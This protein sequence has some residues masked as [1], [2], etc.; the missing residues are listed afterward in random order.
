MLH[1]NTDMIAAIEDL[2]HHVIGK[3]P[4]FCVRATRT[5]RVLL[6]SLVWTQIN[7]K[8]RFCMQRGILVAA[9]YFQRASND[10]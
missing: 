9:Q 7:S 4:R 2:K 10:G 3:G 6:R 1:T 8:S 5:K